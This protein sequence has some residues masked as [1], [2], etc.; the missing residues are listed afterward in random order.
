MEDNNFGQNRMGICCER[1]QGQTYR[2]A[3]SKKKKNTNKDKKKK[4]F[5]TENII[6]LS[7]KILCQKPR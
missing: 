1:S 3:V 5:H 4:I 7:A 6:L 2:V